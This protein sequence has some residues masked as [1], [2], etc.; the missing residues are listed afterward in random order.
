MRQ[1]LLKIGLG[2]LAVLLVAGSLRLGSPVKYTWQRIAPRESGLLF[3][4]LAAQ[5]QEPLLFDPGVEERLKLSHPLAE[6]ARA[7]P[8]RR[9]PIAEGESLAPPASF[10]S[11]GLPRAARDAVRTRHMRINPQGEVQVYIFV[12]E[13][14]RETL[15]ELRNTGATIELEDEPRLIVQARLPVTRLEEAAGLPFVQLVRLPNYGVRMIGLVT[16]QGDTILKTDQVRSTLH[17]D[18][19]GVRVGVISDGI[20][21]IF[22]TG[23]TT[24]G[25][26]SGG[27]ISTGD[28][29]DSTGTRNSSGVLTASTGGITGQSFSASKDLEGLPPAGCAFAGAGAEGAAMLEIVHDLA[30][31]AKLFFANADTDIE[32]SRAVN[33]LASQADIVLDDISFLA[34]PYDGT[35]GVS[36]NTA[37]ALNSSTNP[38]RAYFTAV[39]N[40]AVNHYRGDYVDSGMDGT[41]IV[42]AA[43]DLHLFQPVPGVTTDVLGLGSTVTDK[44]QLGA[45]GEV[46]I[47]LTWND[48]FNSSTN[49]YDLFLMDDNTKAIVAK[50]TNRQGTT[51]PFEFID[52]KGTNSSAQFFDIIIQNPG[53]KAAA[54]NLNLFFFE[55]ECA[56]AGPLRLPGAPNHEEHNYNTVSNSVVAEGDAG[57]SPVSVVSVG[58][59]RASNPTTIEFFSSNGP[60]ID[61]RMKPDVTGVDGVSVTGAGNFPTTFFGTSAASPHAG[62]VAA[63]LLQAAP[64]LLN[65]STGARSNVDARTILRTLI[66]NNAVDLGAPGPD[67]VYGAGRIDALAAANR[68]LPSVNAGANQ[69]VS[70]NV[71]N[72]ASVTLDGSG[73]ID[74]TGCPLT[75]N[76]SG[77][78]GTASGVKPAVTCPFGT[79]NVSLVVTNNGVTLSSSAS[80][81]VMVSDFTVAAS[82]SSATVRAGQTASYTLTVQP[83]MGAFTGAIALGC[84]NLPARAS[85]SFSP[86]S[87]TPGTSSATSTLTVSTTANSMSPRLPLKPPAP[88]WPVT[89]ALGTSVVALI[90]LRRSRRALSASLAVLFLAL[91]VACGGGGSS[92][93]ST[94]PP[95]ALGGTPPGS[96][97]ITISGTS[98]TLVHNATATLVVQ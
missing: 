86:S 41:S 36:T 10:S 34:L 70:G 48:P 76:W 81:Q 68:T 24:C 90:F 57:G 88:W 43:G 8:Q 91:A 22:A 95:P 79:N 49:D 16:T 61:G 27:P 9:G 35:S 6:V 63:L 45:F 11:E 71:P 13:T 75:F 62:G 38:I 55:P 94:P 59:V 64:C 21:G 67:N 15:E 52:F 19:T 18:G 26:V 96:Y 47:I 97:S 40:L 66:L 83:Q 58:A 54:K 37:N 98:G 20:K 31:G 77:S 3:P 12:S 73:S 92:S 14:G 42:G 56:A 46:V 32:F 78:C 84:S 87:V 65:G 44:I 74:P 25:G 82:P 69:L 4:L 28:L 1:V 51:S 93:S 85:C 39:G 5:A 89:I 29:P 72:G 80:V 60:T 50:S 17:I 33:S 53:N 23:C 2:V 30:P 7:V